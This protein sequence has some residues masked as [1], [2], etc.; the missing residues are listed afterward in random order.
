MVN[1]IWPDAQPW[2]SFI[3]TF[4]A[5]IIVWLNRRTMFKRGEGV[6]DVLMPEQSNNLALETDEM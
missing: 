6:T 2:D 4:V 3:F 5:I 1:P